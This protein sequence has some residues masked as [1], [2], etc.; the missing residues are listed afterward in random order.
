MSLAELRASKKTS[1]P[2][3]TYSLCLAQGLVAEAQALTEERDALLLQAR[4]ARSDEPEAPAPPQRMNA[5]VDP[6][7][8]EIDARMVA[9][10]DEM[11]EATGVLR[12]QAVESGKW[13]DWVA[14]NPPRMVERDGKQV[15]HPIDAEVA[16]GYCDADALLDDM[17]TYA[18]SWNGEPLGAGEWAWLVTQAANGDL[19][20][21]CKI[22]VQMHE[23]EGSRAPFSP[24][25]S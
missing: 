3:R 5:P 9:L 15:L 14:A 4:R 25:P 17:E 23:S 16:Y 1:L 20:E 21:M 12:L 8:D 19:R 22:V 6:R 7:Q 24:T 11:R 13:R 18:A 2:E 10:F